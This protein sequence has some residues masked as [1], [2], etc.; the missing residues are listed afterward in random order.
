MPNYL[1]GGIINDAAIKSKMTD[2]ITNKSPKMM[3][4][5]YF[6]SQQELN[7]YASILP[8]NFGI[9][10]TVMCELLD[11]GNC[12]ILEVS[13]QHVFNPFLSLF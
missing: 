4:L 9:D 11:N 2:F 5:G 6:P 12:S 10:D 8:H 3:P 13:K 7:E 1:I